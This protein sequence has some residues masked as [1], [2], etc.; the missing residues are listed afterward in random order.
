MSKRAFLIINIVLTLIFAL[1]AWVQREDDNPDVYVN[2]ST[3]DVIVWISFYALVSLGFALAA[4][5]IRSKLFYVGVL[6]FGLVLL[7]MTGPGLFENLFGSE[8]FEMMKDSMNPEKP[9]VELTRE[10]FGALIA[11]G[12]IVFLWLQPRWIKAPAS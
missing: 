9:R 2:P 7:V 10:F 3:L 1:F 4:F 5:S 6:G 8:D 11:M 12:A